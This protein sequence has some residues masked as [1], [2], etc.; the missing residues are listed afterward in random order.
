MTN[1]I[2][3]LGSLVERSQDGTTYTA[4]PEARGVA[5]PSITQEYVDA[6][7]LQSPGGFREYIKGLKDAGELSV[8]AN[9]TTAGYTQQV[10]DQNFNGT[11]KY[12][13]TLPASPLQST[14]DVFEF[15]GYPTP[16]I[17]TGEAGEIVGMTITI[18]TTGD[19][20]FTA[21]TAL[22]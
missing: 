15:E 2:I 1:A 20:D 21:G 3:A 13:V 6:T 17:E 5:I 7:H 14:G 16:T 11:I 9:Y 22:P 12:R 8:P 19:V 4:I 18:R 10:A